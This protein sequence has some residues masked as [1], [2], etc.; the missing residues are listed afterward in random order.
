MTFFFIFIFI[1]SKVY[2]VFFIRCDANFFKGFFLDF[3][4]F[5][6]VGDM[7]SNCDIKYIWVDK[8][9][10]EQLWNS[11]DEGLAFL[12]KYSSST[13]KKL[14]DEDGVQIWEVIG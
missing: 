2:Q 8:D 1:V 3:I 6:V 14:Y 5:L 11:Q 7:S 13:F 4:F 10:A 12:L 9:M